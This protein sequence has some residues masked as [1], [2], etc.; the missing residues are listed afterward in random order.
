MLCLVL[1]ACL[2]DAYLRNALSSP[3]SSLIGLTVV[4]IGFLTS[5]GFFWVTILNF[6]GHSPFV[7]PT[8]FVSVVRDDSRFF[9]ALLRALERLVFGI[10]STDSSW[11]HSSSGS[12]VSLE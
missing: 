5:L 11:K 8:N 9:P 10:L 7:G 12:H 2:R 6:G 1:L 3:R 4:P